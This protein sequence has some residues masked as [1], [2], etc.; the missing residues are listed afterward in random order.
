[1][2]YLFISRLLYLRYRKLKKKIGVLFKRKKFKTF[3]FQPN[4]SQRA[5]HSPVILLNEFLTPIYSEMKVHTG[6]T[7]TNLARIF[8]RNGPSRIVS[9]IH[10]T[11]CKFPANQ[12]DM[13]G[14]PLSLIKSY[15]VSLSRSYGTN[16][17]PIIFLCRVSFNGIPYRRVS[18]LMHGYFNRSR[19][20][21]R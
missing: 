8:I 3:I 19:Y 7:C 6:K 13:A 16:G 12:T 2:R 10:Q 1:M 14:S 11:A 4:F 20:V 21:A 17:F 15:L 9:T 18:R 5:F